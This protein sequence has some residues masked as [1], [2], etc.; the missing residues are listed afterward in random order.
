MYQYTKSFLDLTISVRELL[1][2]GI[3]V[4]SL[5]LALIEYRKRKEQEKQ[6]AVFRTMLGM[7]RGW[8]APIESAANANSVLLDKAR[9]GR[10]GQELE[11]GIDAQGS[12]L[13][14]LHTGVQRA[15]DEINKKLDG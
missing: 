14:G 6:T 12:Y 3:S 13:H 1:G 10:S 7:V 8:A 4:G 2:F 9:A 15:V 11:S 5:V